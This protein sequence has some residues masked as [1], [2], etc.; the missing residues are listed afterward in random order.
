MSD[1]AALLFGVHAH[2]PAGNFPEVFEQA[3]ARC[4]R[5][6]I[7]VLHAYPE[8]RFALHMSG[9]LIEYLWTRHPEDMAL[10]AQMSRRGQVEW[11]GAG[12]FE[13]VLAAIPQRD[14]IGQLLALSDRIEQRVGQRPEGA[15]LTERVWESS[16]VPALVQA[17]IRYAVVDDYHFFCTGR[18]AAELRGYFSTEEDGQRLDLFPIS[19]ELRYRIPFAPA[20]DAL[21]GLEALA[22]PGE[23]AVYFDD[24]EKFG[25]WPETWQWV[26]EK[27]WLAEFIERVLASGHLRPETF[28]EFHARTASRGIVYL[29]STSY[30]EMNE[31]TLPAEP[32][33]RYA[34]LVQAERDAARYGA[35][36][37]FLRGGIWRNFLSRYPEAN[38]MHKRMLGLSQRV[39]A[40]GQDDRTQL[41]RRLYAA[42]ANDA[43]WHGL[44]GG[45]YLPHLRRSVWRNLLELEAQ[46]DTLAPRPPLARGDCD[47]DGVEELFLTGAALQAV[48]RLDGEAALHELSSYPLAQNFG[49]TLRRQREHYH[50]RALRGADSPPQSGGIASAHERF[51]LKHVIGPADLEPD[52]RGRTLFRDTLLAPGSAPVELRNYQLVATAGDGA[53]FAAPA[54][55]IT[56][57]IALRGAVL[58][59]TW[60]IQAVRGEFVTELDLALPSCDGFAG[61]Y[62]VGGAALCG[63]GQ[64]LELQGAAELALDDRFMQGRVALH[65]DPP[66]RVSAQ[67][68]YTVSQSEDGLERVMQSATLRLAWPIDRD[69]AAIGVALRIEVDGASPGEA[70]RQPGTP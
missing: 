52:P 61:R 18:S 59:V 47:L 13:P 11:F 56:K 51:S 60:R 70:P 64:P 24:I 16:V 20:A 31:W 38:W 26:Y 53:R 41:L 9:P 19:E 39:A 3:H 37:A 63:F 50:A 4:Y 40:A 5:P 62:L 21:S 57:A 30:V 65:I 25:I 17:G 7:R 32:A 28:R 68:C 45:I 54:A 12:D 22:G 66:A 67:P 36:K 34:A 55:Q 23:A 33:Q 42:Q 10:L 27:R 44:F 58:E 14:R 29:P 1:R 15:W 6:F 43:Y 35:H 46:L 49:D 8:F 2:Q 69:Q 48:I